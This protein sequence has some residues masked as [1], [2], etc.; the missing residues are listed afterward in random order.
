LKQKTT[1]AQPPAT[2]IHGANT[3]QRARK[4]Y[5]RYKEKIGSPNKQAKKHAIPFANLIGRRLHNDFA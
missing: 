3:K 2:P 1:T 5:G 4:K